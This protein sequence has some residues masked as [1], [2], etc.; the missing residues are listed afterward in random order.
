VCKE[1]RRGKRRF[2]VWDLL[3]DD[4]CIRAELDFLSTTEVGGLNLAAAEED[5][6]SEA[7]EW[8]LQERRER[9]EEREIEAERLGTKVEEPL[10]LTTPAF[11]ASRN[12]E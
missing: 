4:R 10:F 5:A 12:E 11:M 7:S 2:A 3:A 8:E 6:Q 1:T 9:E